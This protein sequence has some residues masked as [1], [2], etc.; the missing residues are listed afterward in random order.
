MVDALDG[1][2]HHNC[3][4]GTVNLGIQTRIADQIHNPSSK[5]KKKC[6]RHALCV[7]VCVPLSIVNGEVELF[8]EHVKADALVHSAVRLEDEQTRILHKLIAQGRQEVVV[9]KHCIT[10]AQLQFKK[11]KKKKAVNTPITTEKKKRPWFEP[12]QSQT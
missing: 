3:P 6:K 8:G 9:L 5:K 10:L 11:K 2:A 1:S 4:G 7:Y 12:R